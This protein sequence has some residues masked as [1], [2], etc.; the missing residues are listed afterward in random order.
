MIELAID[1]WGAIAL[2]Q[3]IVGQFK[4]QFGKPNSGS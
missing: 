4:L 2:A 3:L 1:I